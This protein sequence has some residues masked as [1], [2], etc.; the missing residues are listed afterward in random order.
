MQSSNNTTGAA[1]PYGYTTG[2]TYGLSSGY[3]NVTVNTTGA[4]G[5]G[6]ITI[7]AADSADVKFELVEQGAEL[8]RLDLDDDGNII[9]NFFEQMDDKIVKAV[10]LPESD[11]SPIESIRFNTLM[12]GCSAGLGI[13]PVSFIKQH[14]LSRHFRFSEE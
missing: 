10:F 1:N 3:G 8:M 13:L 14:S 6:A 11:M 12:Q 7:N 2:N 4:T 9:V 5:F